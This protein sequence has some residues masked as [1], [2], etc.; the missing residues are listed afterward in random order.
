MWHKIFD[1]DLVM[2][3]KNK[4]TLALNTPTF[5]GMCNFQLS[6][7]LMYEFDYDYIKNK[8][9][10]NSKLLFADTDCLMY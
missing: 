6:K 7:A 2:I 8:Y 10:N 1:N 5:I 9:E 4:V 3:C